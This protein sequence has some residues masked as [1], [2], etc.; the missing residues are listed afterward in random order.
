MRVFYDI[1]LIRDDTPT[2][3][4]RWL[5]H[6]GMILHVLIW[7][8]ILTALAYHGTLKMMKAFEQRST[9]ASL[10]QRFV[11]SHPGIHDEFKYLRTLVSEIRQ[12]SQALETIDQV[13]SRRADLGG[14]LLGLAMPLPTRVQVLRLEQFDNNQLSFDITVP[15]AMTNA[16]SSTSLIA[17]WNAEELL[18]NR[19]SNL[20]S[21]SS[22]RRRVGADSSVVLRFE[23]DIK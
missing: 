10:H 15:S 4:R 12:D 16:V 20:R 17:A 22:H 18:E 2:P 21:V 19:I 3:A 9:I 7:G 8:A 1:N 6:F 5:F 13:L 14:I 23:C 11:G